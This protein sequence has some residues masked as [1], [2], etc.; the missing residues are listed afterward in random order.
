MPHFLLKWFSI[1]LGELRSSSSLCCLQGVA[2]LSHYILQLRLLPDGP[3]FVF[4]ALH[5]KK[6]QDYAERTF[7][8]GGSRR[9]IVYLL[10]DH[11]KLENVALS[12]QSIIGCLEWIFFTL[13]FLRPQAAASLEK[14]EL[15]GPW[16]E[17]WQIVSREWAFF[18]KK[19]VASQE[20]LS[21]LVACPE[22]LGII[23][24]DPCLVL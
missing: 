9:K 1:S 14:Y 23:T 24:P 22:K 17:S 2:H 6:C 13:N 5:Y 11:H 3:L 18:V 16:Y 19:Q 7:I 10:H 20:V 4:L 8:I 21:Y 15:I 12:F